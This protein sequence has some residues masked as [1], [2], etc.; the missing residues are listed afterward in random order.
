MNSIVV[1]KLFPTFFQVNTLIRKPQ[2]V[3]RDVFPITSETFG[4]LLLLLIREILLLY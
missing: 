4:K 3:F 1:Y 2:C